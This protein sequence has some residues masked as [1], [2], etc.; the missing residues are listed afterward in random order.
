MTS[1]GYAYVLPRCFSESAL[2]NC[3]SC[4][5][6]I[7]TSMVV[8]WK[9]IKHNMICPQGFGVEKW[10]FPTK[11]MVETNILQHM[12]CPYFAALCP[13]LKC[14][15]NLP[16]YLGMPLPPSGYSPFILFHLGTSLLVHFAVKFRANMLIESTD[17]WFH[18]RFGFVYRLWPLCSLYPHPR[19]LKCSDQWTLPLL[20]CQAETWRR[21]CPTWRLFNAL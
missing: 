8:S 9:K 14:E 7:L 4:H 19:G 6:A 1:R 13:C 17:T 2:S 21:P 18:Q 16:D 5:R 3:F 10:I 20:G 11:K 12:C 15:E